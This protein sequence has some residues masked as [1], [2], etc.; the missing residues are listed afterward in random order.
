MKVLV[1]SGFLG[2]GKTTFIRTLLKRTGIYAAV[3]E[4]EYGETD[5]DGRA[6]RKDSP[7]QVLEFME[8]CV[9]C[10]KKDS[11]ANSVIAISAGL[12]PDWLI[13]EPSG[14]GKLGAILDNIRRVSYEKIVPAGSIL[15]IA[16]RSFQ[17][18]LNE[19]PEIFEDQMRHADTIVLSKT[20]TEEASVVEDVVR[21]IR[22]YNRN[23]PVLT[24]HYADQDD[25]WWQQL[26]R[27]ADAADLSSRPAGKDGQAD[28]DDAASTLDQ[29]TFRTARVRNAG[30]L[31]V[32]LE[33]ILHGLFGGIVRAKGVLYMGEEPVRFDVADGLYAVTGEE[34]AN[35]KTQCVFIG[36]GMREDA[37]R[38]RLR[39]YET[40]RMRRPDRNRKE[41]TT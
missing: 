21:R 26:L 6:I 12:D 17:T 22:A 39:A 9:C 34:E 24:T 31:T 33:D 38:E 19:F 8:G 3:L 14:V 11:F 27:M 15:V 32:F 18:V 16:P 30:D 2:A 25:D 36:Q 37:L 29:I 23:A 28:E 10:T 1:V 20:E 5:L 40:V 7:L 35:V 41:E 4:N 13:V